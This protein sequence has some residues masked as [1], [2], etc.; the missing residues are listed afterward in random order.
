MMD[1]NEIISLDVGEK[2]IGV[3]R[4]NIIAGIATPLT[5]INVD[6]SEIDQ[7]KQLAEENHVSV[8]VVGLPRNMQGEETK[9]SEVIRLFTTRLENLPYS[10]VFQDESLTSVNA[11]SKVGAVKDKGVIDALAA[12]Q[13]LQDYLE[14]Q[15]A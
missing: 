3:A 15:R 1:E 9:Q 6:G 11:K 4:A 12:S 13:F 5:T 10:L 2:R 14:Q 8:I 7:I